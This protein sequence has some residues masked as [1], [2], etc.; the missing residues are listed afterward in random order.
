MTAE[1]TMP[2]EE[3]SVDGTGNME[4]AQP[5]DDRRSE[6]RESSRPPTEEGRGS[7]ERPQRRLPRRAEEQNKSLAQLHAKGTLFWKKP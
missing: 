3:A 5:E 7:L 1:K 4:I 2:H 6:I